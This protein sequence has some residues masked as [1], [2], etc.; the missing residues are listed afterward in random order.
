[1]QMACNFLFF[2]PLISTWIRVWSKENTD[3]SWNFDFHSGR[4]Q[5]AEAVTSVEAPKEMPIR[6]WLLLAAQQVEWRGQRY[7]FLVYLRTCSLSP[8]ALEPFVV[9]G[10]DGCLDMNWHPNFSRALALWEDTRKKFVS[11][12]IMDW[13]W[14]LVFCL[15]FG[16]ITSEYSTT[17][18]KE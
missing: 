1:M 9:L 2:T 8:S 14:T 16:L 10:L 15:T 11:H 4:S 5:K 17:G 18:G 13:S 3:L 6:D 12:L 7:S